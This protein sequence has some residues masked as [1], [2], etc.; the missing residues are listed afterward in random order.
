MQQWYDEKGRAVS[1]TSRYGK[2]AAAMV[3]AS[4]RIGTTASARLSWVVRFIAEQPESWSSRYALERGDCLLA[5]GGWA[6]P[7]NWR[8][9]NELPDSVSEA[10][11]GA[12]HAELKRVVTEAVSAPILADVSIASDGLNVSL[13]RLSEKSA[14]PAVWAVRYTHSSLRSA[15]LHAVKDL[16]LQAGDRLIGC[17]YC[18]APIRAVRKQKYCVDTQCSQKFHNENKAEQRKKSRRGQQR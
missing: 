10:D 3:S 13:V 5:L 6:R 16:I 12:V 7:S 2:R 11:V 8:G 4:A 9:G 15:V 1:A 14:K 18:G 17:R